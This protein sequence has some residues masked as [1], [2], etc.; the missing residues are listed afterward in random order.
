MKKRLLD[1]F[2]NKL[3]PSLPVVNDPALFW[4]SK[5]TNVSRNFQP[6]GEK[7]RQSVRDDLWHGSWKLFSVFAGVWAD[8][9][10]LGGFWMGLDCRLADVFFPCGAFSKSET[11]P[12][13][14]TPR[15]ILQ[16]SENLWVLMVLEA[17]SKPS[18]NLWFSMVF[19][20]FLCFFWVF[21]EGHPKKTQQNLQISPHLPPPADRVTRYLI[22]SAMVGFVVF[23]ILKGAF[24]KDPERWENWRFARVVATLQRGVFLWVLFGCFFVVF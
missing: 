19:Y 6:I 3:F 12:P 18:N 23:P 16:A 10:C 17:R 24:W 15:T 2:L 20:G 4:A 14:T 7:T 5:R 21:L 9:G 13:Q 11:P 22:I 8:P 1:S